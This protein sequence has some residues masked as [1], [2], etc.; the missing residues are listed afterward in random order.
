MQDA[1]QTGAIDANSQLALETVKRIGQIEAEIDAN[2]ELARSYGVQQD[3]IDRERELARAI[4]KSA[5][6]AKRRNEEAVRPPRAPTSDGGVAPFS[7]DA[8]AA[9]L[10]DP[11]VEKNALRKAALKTAADLNIREAQLDLQR[12]K[13]GV[14]AAEKYKEVVVAEERAKNQVETANT[15]FIASL[16]QNVIQLSA[17]SASAAAAGDSF[18]Q[19]VRGFAGDLVSMVGSLLIQLGTAAIFGGTLSTAVPFLAPIAGGPAGIAVGAAAIAGGLGLIA[20]GSAIKS[21]GNP[22]AASS[23][24]GGGGGG[25]LPGIAVPSVPDLDASP[26]GFDQRFDA[27]QRNTQQGP[28]NVFNFYGAVGNTDRARR[29]QE[30][31]TRQR[32]LV[33]A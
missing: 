25:A 13:A 8:I 12:A 21:G 27:S 17:T 3:V 11:L 28:A 16:A 24:G 6:E 20:A 32:R 23:A 9:E 22:G 10:S 1:L 26:A 18:G 2:R 4:G 15:R 30:R 31:L 29:E 5:D 14:E 33:G 7:R 19:V